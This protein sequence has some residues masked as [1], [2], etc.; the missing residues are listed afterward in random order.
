MAATATH[1]IVVRVSFK[2]GMEE[3][4]TNVLKTE[5]V[6][7]AK[8][9]AGFVA[10]YWMHADDGATGTSV[11]LFDSLANAQAEMARRSTDMPLES[12]VT[13]DSAE[14]LEIVASA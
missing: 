8:A 14:I 6:P 3:T 7:G 9:A 1:A 11:E 13:V 12:P 4:A 10:G 5:V 2:K